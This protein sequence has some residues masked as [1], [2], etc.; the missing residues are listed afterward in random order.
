M[1]NQAT[2]LDPNSIYEIHRRPIAELRRNQQAAFISAGCALS[3]L[4]SPDAISSCVAWSPSVAALVPIILG[5]TG[6]SSQ[7]ITHQSVISIARFDFLKF[8]R[9]SS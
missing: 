9:T 3:S 5:G 1:A 4:G 7:V 2:K 6:A 8:Q